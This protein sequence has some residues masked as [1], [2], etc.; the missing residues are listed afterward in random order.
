MSAGSR[1]RIFFG[2]QW[3]LIGGVVILAFLVLGYARAW[4]QDYQ[5]GQEIARLETEVKRLESQRLQ[6]LELLRYV[7]SPAF[8]EDKARTELNLIK[9]GE[10]VAIIATSATHIPS[11][12][13]GRGM[14]E[15]PRLSNPAQW[16]NY[17]MH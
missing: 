16:W 12:Q 4:Y 10:Q 14:V 3:F 17:F 6:T 15:S 13:P 1:W 7:Q 11:G 2:S 9:P 5:V 8:V